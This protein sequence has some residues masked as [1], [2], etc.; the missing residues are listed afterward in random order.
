MYIIDRNDIYPYRGK[1]NT[2]P[3]RHRDVPGCTWL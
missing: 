3:V 1:G 2:Q